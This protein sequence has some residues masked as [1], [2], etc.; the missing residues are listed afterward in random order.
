MSAV[1]RSGLGSAIRSSW[2]RGRAYLVMTK[3]RI[4]TQ[5]LIITLPAMLLAERG[6]PPAKVVFATLAGG[7]MAAA[8]AGVFNCVLDV[9]IDAV[10]NRTRH[11]PLVQQV[12]PMG[13]AV[14]FG[15][16]LGCGSATLL[17][18]TTNLLTTV[19]T[20]FAIFFYVV[21]YTAVLK[22]RTTQNV[23]WGGVC[24][25]MPVLIGWSAVTGTVEWPAFA[26]FAVV[27]FWT[28][29]HSW[30]LA[31]KYREDYVRA[32]V[33]M[34]P[35]KGT[36]EQVV[37]RISVYSWAAVTSTFLLIPVTGWVFAAAAL[38]CGAW[39]LVAVHRLR[40]AVRSGAEA[41]AM[42]V[43]HRSNLFLCSIFAALAVDSLTVPRW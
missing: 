36:G 35:V 26:L 22:R 3:P 12:V 14:V 6:L 40:S 23:V 33:P 2:P 39:F 42:A 20:V 31:M 32:G 17:L 34:L 25:C 24:G 19:L 1:V 5:L 18:L 10:M 13:R 28:P 38:A 7:A 27:F 4:V 8:S 16:L 37:T 41:D 11:R 43:F 9:D 30:A 21:V 29:P 15:A